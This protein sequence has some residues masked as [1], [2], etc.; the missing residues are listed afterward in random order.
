[1]QGKYYVCCS[2]LAKPTSHCHGTMVILSFLIPYSLKG[3][4][5]G[6]DPA[7]K[8]GTSYWLRR[9][10]HIGALANHLRELGDQGPES[11]NDLTL[12]NVLTI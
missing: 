4:Q 11:R 9:N 1:M 8:V 2:S 10:K 12:K 5:Y 3:S 6:R 7:R